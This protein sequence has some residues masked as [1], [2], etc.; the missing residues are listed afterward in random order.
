MRPYL[1]PLDN[2]HIDTCTTE[3]EDGLADQSGEDDGQDG[4]TDLTETTAE[5]EQASQSKA[6]QIR[7]QVRQNQAS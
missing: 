6:S 2:K 4:S 3:S 7:Q 5:A 1:S